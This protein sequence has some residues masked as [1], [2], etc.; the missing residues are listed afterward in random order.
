M[1]LSRSV[2]FILRNQDE[3]TPLGPRGRRW[4]KVPGGARFADLFPDLVGQTL[5]ID[6]AGLELVG[7]PRLALCVQWLQA[8]GYL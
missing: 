1:K 3:Q 6:G 5:T 7:K 8:N 2:T 4:A